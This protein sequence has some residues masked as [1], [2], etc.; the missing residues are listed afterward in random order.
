MNIQELCFKLYLFPWLV[1]LA[2]K[3]GLCGI[4]YIPQK[5][6][7]FPII[8]LAPGAS[9]GTSCKYLINRDDKIELTIFNF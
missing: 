1:K 9:L 8:T 2:D 3:K 7:R 5:V 6:T 4:D